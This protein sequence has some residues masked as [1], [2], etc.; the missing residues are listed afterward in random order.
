MTALHGQRRQGET[1][2]T[3]EK[4]HLFSVGNLPPIHLPQAVQLRFVHLVQDQSGG[5]AGIKAHVDDL[6]RDDSKRL[7]LLQVQ[8]DTVSITAHHFCSLELS[9]PLRKLHLRLYQITPLVKGR[10]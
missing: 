4:G 1:K 3:I 8:T 9:Q 6:V 7:L 10:T 5:D 2:G